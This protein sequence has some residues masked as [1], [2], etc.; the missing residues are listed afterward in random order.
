[1]GPVKIPEENRIGAFSSLKYNRLLASLP[2]SWRPYLEVIHFCDTL[3]ILVFPSFLLMGLFY[4]ACLTRPI[5]QP[6]E[7]FELAVYLSLWSIVMR[8]ALVAFNETVNADFDRKVTRKLFRTAVGRV[9][10]KTR[11]FSFSGV[12]FG[13]GMYILSYVPNRSYGWAFVTTMTMMTYPF[14]KRV[15]FNPRV[16]I[17]LAYA[18]AVFQGMATAGAKFSPLSGNYLSTVCLG[19]ACVLLVVIIDTVNA[20]RYV[21]DDAKAG[22][23]SLPVLLDNHAGRFL[24]FLT[25]LMA[26]FLSLVGHLTDFSPFYSL[27]PWASCYILFS[28]MLLLVDLRIP[29]DCSWWVARVYPGA[30]GGL[31]WGFFVEYCYRVWLLS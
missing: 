4:G 11:A 10:T 5:I 9:I 15:V 31:V 2:V 21:R 27:V 7:L 19:L 29:A 14:A 22:I 23:K 18:S 3:G 24:W 17:A 16:I 20:F 12:L 1:M 25:N 13:L 6:D 8:Y 30:L 28:A 26:L